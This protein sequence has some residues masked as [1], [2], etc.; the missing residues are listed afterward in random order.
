M[1]NITGTYRG[2]WKF[3]DTV[4]NSS[5]FPDFRKES[6]TSVTE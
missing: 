1:D 2:A 5:K 4:N 3:L 6:G